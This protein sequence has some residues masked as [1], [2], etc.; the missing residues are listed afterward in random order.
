MNLK[1][2]EEQGFTIFKVELPTAK[3]VLFTDASFANARD[4]KIQFGN[5]VQ[6]M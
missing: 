4:M 2:T 6:F 1:G 3:L 5:V